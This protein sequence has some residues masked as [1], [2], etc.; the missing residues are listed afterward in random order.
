MLGNEI[1]FMTSRPKNYIESIK[2]YFKQE[3]INYKTIITDCN[4]SQ[5]IIINDFAPTN[6][7]PS[8]DAI[9]V[10]RNGILSEYI[11]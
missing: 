5:R 6:P 11:S 7:F 8:C 10:K 4:H 9:S 3:N 1:I 2:E